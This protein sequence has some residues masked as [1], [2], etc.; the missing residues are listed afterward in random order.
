MRTNNYVHL[1]CDVKGCGHKVDIPEKEIDSY[2]WLVG[3]EYTDD[4]RRTKKYD[5]CVECAMAWHRLRQKQ[6]A[7]ID[8]FIS[9]GSIK[10][11][12]G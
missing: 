8:S 1:E 6:D 2:G 7:D 5:L 9:T 3:A 4:K 11:L 10:N 12:I